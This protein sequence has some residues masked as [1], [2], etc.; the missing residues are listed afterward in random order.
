[1][2]GD[3]ITRDPWRRRRRG[4]WA[5]GIVFAVLAVGQAALAHGSWIIAAMGVIGLV[6]IAV[7]MRRSAREWAQPPTQTAAAPA[8]PGGG[9]RIVVERDAEGYADRMR[10][11][12]VFVDG[13]EVG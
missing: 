11:Y 2:G 12:R 3:D 8:P 1:M 7:G 5:A 13:H 4:Y 10:A 6:S 9:A